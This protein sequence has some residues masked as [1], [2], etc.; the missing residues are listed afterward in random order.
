LEIRAPRASSVI[1]QRIPHDAAAAFLEWQRGITAAAARFPGYQT[2]EIYP[3]SGQQEEWV[4]ILHFDDPKTL[5]DWL[6]S[7]RRAEWVAKLPCKT[8]DFRMK[9]VPAGFGAWFAGVAADGVPLPHWKMA[10]T[11]LVGLYPTVMLL[12]LFL[13][14]HTQ[15]FGLAGAMLIGNVASVCFLEWLGTPFLLTP[16]LGRWLHA[17]TKEGRTQSA[18]GAV[19]IVG[20]LALLTFLFSL[21]TG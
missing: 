13:S 11:V 10:L 2:T 14:P 18:V 20:A 5:Q 17:N 16:L 4:V 8:R 6:D 1:V 15:R 9:L 7:P 3:P 19:L 21:V 12:T